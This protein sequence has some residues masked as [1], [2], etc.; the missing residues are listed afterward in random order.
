MRLRLPIND[1]GTVSHLLPAKT[2]AHSTDRASFT[3]APLY[4]F[5][6]PKWGMPLP[7]PHET[8]AIGVKLIFECRSLECAADSSRR[9]ISAL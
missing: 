8:K 3:F 9:R 6:S 1:A 2:R 7:G 4:C 5:I